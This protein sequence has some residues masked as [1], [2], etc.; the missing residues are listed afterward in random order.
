MEQIK[1]E[2]LLNYLCETEETAEVDILK[3][4]DGKTIF[5]DN[6]EYIVLT[7]D[8]ADVEYYQ[9]QKNLIEEMG[10]EAFSEWAQS[11]ILTHYTSQ[12]FRDIFDNIQEETNYFEIE[13]LRHMGELEKEMQE[14]NCQ[15]EDEFLRYLCEEDSVEWFKWNYG[16]EEY[17]KIIVQNNLIDWDSVIEFCKDMD[18]RGHLLASY[19]GDEL[20][21]ENGLFAYRIN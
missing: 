13:D 4:D 20:E 6:A 7:E 8:E 18:G 16:E 11:E 19:D 12:Y 17:N 21:L 14:A 3:Y 9:Q 2:S 5:V 10:L 1:I 15:D